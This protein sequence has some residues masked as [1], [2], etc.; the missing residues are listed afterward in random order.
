MNFPELERATQDRAKAFYGLCDKII[1]VAS[2][3]LAVTVT[4]RTS[5]LSNINGK[6]Q[7]PRLLIWAWIALAV[8]VAAGLITHFGLVRAQTRAIREMIAG[9]PG[10]GIPGAFFTFCSFVMALSFLLALISF[11]IFAALNTPH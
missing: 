3:L 5:L 6:I 8:T 2:G 11:V 9:R 7:A 1:T 10:A 4:F